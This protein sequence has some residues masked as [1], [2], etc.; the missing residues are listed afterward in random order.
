MGIVWG[1]GV[2]HTISIATEGIDEEE[3]CRRGVEG[4]QDRRRKAQHEDDGHLLGLAKG[5]PEQGGQG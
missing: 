3:D 5:F 4:D 1:I 2:P